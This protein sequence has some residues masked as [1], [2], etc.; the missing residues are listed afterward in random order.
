M[1]LCEPLTFKGREGSGHHDGRNAYEN[2]QLAS[3]TLD[4]EKFDLTYL[5]WGRYLYNPDSTP[6]AYQRYLKKTYGDAAEHIELALANSSRI[7]PLVTTA[8]LPSASNHSLW[9]ELYTPIS[10]LPSKEK[11]LYGD[12]PAPH[13]VSAISPLDPQIFMSID[14]YARALSGGTVTSRYNPLEVAQWIDYIVSRSSDALAKAKATAAGRMASPAF[15]RAEEDI[16]ILNGLGGYYA[17]LFRAALCYALFQDTGD[18]QLATEALKFYRGACESWKK[19]ATRAQS[20]YTTDIS[21]GSIPVR[22]GHWADRI[23]M[24]EKDIVALE[25]YFATADVRA[26]GV[27][28]VA[29]ITSPR[30]RPDF[31][32]SHTP[33]QSFHPGSELQ[34]SLQASAQATEAKLWYRH[35]THGERWLSMPMQRKGDTFSAAIP[36]AYTQSPFPLQYY[37]ELRTEHEAALYPP[38]NETLSNQPYFAIHHRDS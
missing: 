36:D 17:G 33:A 7:L 8:W 34:L 31:A 22:R 11:P 5:L 25:Q 12:S 19:M 14:D 13:N 15:R 9:V 10:I 37:F 28:A 26:S 38:L 18:K 4:T 24:I 27:N 35:V 32:A 20:V 30:H 21:Y 1:E 29:L 16:L 3:S 2:H 23:P 6:D